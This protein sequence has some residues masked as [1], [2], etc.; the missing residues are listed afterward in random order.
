MSRAEEIKSYL[1]VR[2]LNTKDTSKQ[3]EEEDSSTNVG[4]E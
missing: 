4:G 2:E 1:A 3:E